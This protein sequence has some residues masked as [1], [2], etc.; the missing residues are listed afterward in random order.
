MRRPP[1]KH[2]QVNPPSTTIVDRDHPDT[3]TAKPQMTQIC[4]DDRRLG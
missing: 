3:A 4:A 2:R 1:S